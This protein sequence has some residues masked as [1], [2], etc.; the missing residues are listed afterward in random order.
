MKYL[1]LIVSILASTEVFSQNYV[2]IDRS[3]FDN[4]SDSIFKVEEASR[5]VSFKLCEYVYED[6]YSKNQVVSEVDHLVYSGEIDKRFITTGGCYSIGT[7]FSDFVY[8]ISEYDSESN[9]YYE[10][11]ILYLQKNRSDD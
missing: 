9:P 5:S 1:I 11:K 10:L 4:L 3:E 7:E 8:S 2:E 6:L